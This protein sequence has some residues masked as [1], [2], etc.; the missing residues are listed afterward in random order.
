MKRLNPSAVLILL[1]V[2][3]LFKYDALY[4]QLN[5]KVGYNGVKLN[6]KK[7]IEIID[8]FNTTL[9]S[10]STTL[11]DDLNK[12]K[13][14]HGIEIGLRYRIR[15][16]GFELSWSSISTKND[17]YATL[18]NDQLF[19]DKWYYSLTEYSLGVENYF[20]KLGY[21]A[22]LG[23]Q[24]YRIKTDITGVQRKKSPVVTESGATSKF[25]LIFQFPGD[26]VGI[27][28]KPYFQIPLGKYNISSFDQT[29]NEQIQE[30]YQSTGN[31]DE[32]MQLFG[33]SILLYN[34]RQN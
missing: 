9:L 18:S 27:A 28:F 29:L 5:L 10:Q 22:A 11:H 2:L 23:Y 21:G 16:I 1:F 20:G 3:S 31:Y 14:M 7:T 26:L 19:Q 8:K 24:T 15:N 12:I 6:P 17:V 4:S 30:G 13:N 32:D 25:Y 33:I 34:G